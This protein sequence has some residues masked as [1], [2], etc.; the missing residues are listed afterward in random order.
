MSTCQGQFDAF[1]SVLNSLPEEH[2][3]FHTTREER[4]SNDKPWLT[5]G[6]NALV[7]DRQ[8]GPESFTKGTQRQTTPKEDK[9]RLRATFYLSK[10]NKIGESNSVKAVVEDNQDNDR[11]TTIQVTLVRSVRPTVW[12]GGDTLALANN[13]NKVFKEVTSDLQPLLPDA[14]PV[15]QIVPDGFIIS[16]ADCGLKLSKLCVHKTMGPDNIPQLVSERLLIHSRSSNSSH[17]QQLGERNILPIPK[18]PQVTSLGKY[19]RPNALTPVPPV[20]SKVSHLSV[21][22]WVGLTFF[23][24]LN[25]LSMS[26][27]HSGRMLFCFMSYF[28]RS[29]HLSF[30]GSSSGAGSVDSSI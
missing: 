17:L 24:M 8:N 7:Q 23:I 14:V 6:F 16:V 13:I 5:K 18:T 21:V 3:K 30:Q 29:I 15:P 25:Q 19:L 27:A 10:V 9:S 20:L 2:F 11:T 12:T 22:S 26:D 1:A 4:H 28:N